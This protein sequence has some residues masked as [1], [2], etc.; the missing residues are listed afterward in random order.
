MKITGW[1]MFAVQKVRFKNVIFKNIVKY[2]VKIIV[3]YL[4]L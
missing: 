1:F 2:L 3:Y 4:K